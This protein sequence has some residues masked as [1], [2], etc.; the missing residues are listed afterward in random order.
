MIHKLNKSRSSNEAINEQ[1][2]SSYLTQ[3]RYSN[4]IAVLGKVTHSRHEILQNFNIEQK[5]SL[6]IF[7]I[8]HLPEFLF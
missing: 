6:Y 2:L 3:Q 7:E 1:M 4:Y 8:Q 5:T